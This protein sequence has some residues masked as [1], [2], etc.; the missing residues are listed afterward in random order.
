MTAI[1]VASII[2][3]AL[4][5]RLILYIVDWHNNDKEAR[6]NATLAKNRRAWANEIER[7]GRRLRE[8]DRLAE[9]ERQRREILDAV[10]SKKLNVKLVGGAVQYAEAWE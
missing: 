1:V 2:A 10:A 3:G 6:V 7:A 9:E 5:A 8:A 4:L